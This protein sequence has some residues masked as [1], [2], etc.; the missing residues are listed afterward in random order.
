MVFTLKKDTLT[1]EIVVDSLRSKK[2]DIKAEKENKRSGE[3]HMMRRRMKF[4][5]MNLDIA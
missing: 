3:L 4:K 2:I 5:Q 1:P